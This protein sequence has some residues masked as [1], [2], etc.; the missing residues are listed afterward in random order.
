MNS[1]NNQEPQNLIWIS[2]K[3][4]L[5]QRCCTCGMYTDRTVST[6][7]VSYHTQTVRT[8]DTAH[9]LVGCL[10]HLLLGPLGWL[11]A[12]LFHGGDETSSTKTKTTKQK[13]KIRIPQCLLC[14]GHQ[15]IQPLDVSS[16]GRRYA[17]DVHPEFVRQF[18]MENSKTNDRPR[19]LNR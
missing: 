1:Q 8:N 9:F 14:S 4:K 16:G 13:H 3:D 2:R 6:T 10:L 19:S 5:P 17:F 7:H 11:I 12:L 18:E 15:K